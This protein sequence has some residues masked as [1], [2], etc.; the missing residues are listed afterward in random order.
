MRK[1]IIGHGTGE[2][3]TA[4]PGWVDLEHLAEVEITSEDEGYPMESALIPGVG[5]VGGRRS[6][7]SRRSAS[8]SMNR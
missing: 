7:G 4:E 1:R 8:C 6:L 2:V 5:P 3:A